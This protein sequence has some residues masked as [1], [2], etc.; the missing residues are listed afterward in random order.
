MNINDIS[1]CIY[2][3]L[4]FRKKKI[5]CIDPIIDCVRWWLGGWLILI[6]SF[7]ILE[8]VYWYY[9]TNLETKYNNPIDY[10]AGWCLGWWF[11]LIAPTF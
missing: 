5:K 1:D 9:A 2:Q 8:Y 10:Y 7:D 4:Y 6:D 3:K 11:W